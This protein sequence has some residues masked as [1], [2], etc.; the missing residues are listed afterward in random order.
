M[1]HGSRWGYKTEIHMFPLNEMVAMD[2]E[3]T[4]VCK[5]GVAKYEP[6][7]TATLSSK[8]CLAANKIAN[9]IPSI[10]QKRADCT[11]SWKHR[12]ASLSTTPNT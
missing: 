12:L 6:K 2:K 11:V 5:H 4:E 10:L 8:C 3:W 1:L 9:K 7:K